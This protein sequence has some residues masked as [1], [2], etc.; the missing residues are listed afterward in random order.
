MRIQQNFTVSYNYEI[1]FTRNL[2]Q[3]ENPLLQEV[4]SVDRNTRVAFVI[5]SGVVAH[6]TDLEKEISAY[7]ATT[8]NLTLAAAPLVVP[9]GEIVKNDLDY[10]NQTLSLINEVKIDRHAYLIAIGGGA[11]LDMVGFAA[12]VGHRG[13]RHIRIPTTV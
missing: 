6:H 7:L 8:P 13:I 10:Y 9:G 1:R 5:D 2:F 12:A 3:L 4:I 11:V